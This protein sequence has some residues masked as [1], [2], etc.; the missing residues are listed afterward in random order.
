MRGRPR[1]TQ[2]ARQVLAQDRRVL[3]RLISAVENRDPKV[4]PTL[5]AL[6]PRTGRARVI[7]IAGPLGVGKSSLLNG[8]LA[9]LRAAGRTVGVVAVD[10]SSPFTGGS[11]LG[12]RIRLE[13]EPGD[14]GVFIRSMASRGHLGGI[15]AATLEVTRLLDAFGM[16]FVLVETVG[17]GQVDVEVREVAS[18]AVV[19]LVPHLGDE[20]QTL[21][22]GLFEI[23]DVFCVNKSD[24][25]GADLAAK[26]LRELISL[27]RSTGGWT[28]R[29]LTA[30]ARDGVGIAELWAAIE[31]HERFLDEAGTRAATERRRLS[32]EIVGLVTERVGHD[33]AESLRRDPRLSNLLDRVLSREV[34][35][36]SAVEQIL[37]AGPRRPIR[38]P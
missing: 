9:H 26:D 3:G 32:A 31:A 25:P 30:S 37:R 11:V 38:V 21:K 8:L 16:D 10:P 13:R 23:A 6:Y 19:V 29:I 18:T 24:L 12:D 33:L 22:A 17:S 20:V 35:P 4:I 7:G 27:A 15:A 1:L 28:P 36:H 2:A 5:R 34:D 14:P